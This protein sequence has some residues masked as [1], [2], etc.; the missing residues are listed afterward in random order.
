LK[1]QLLVC[2]SLTDKQDIMPDGSDAPKRSRA[3]EVLRE[4]LQALTSKI[5]GTVSPRK[6]AKS[7][8]NSDVEGAL[9]ALTELKAIK[10]V[11]DN[12]EQTRQKHEEFDKAYADISRK[13]DQIK[14]MQEELRLLKKS[15]NTIEKQ[16]TK[17][18]Q[19]YTDA[20]PKLEATGL[21]LERFILTL[22]SHYFEMVPWAKT[23]VKD[24]T[25]PDE[26]S[27]EDVPNYVYLQQLVLDKVGRIT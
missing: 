20:I 27:W 18:A 7:L 4:P 21:G 9:K 25:K 19:K 26:F 14:K 12:F 13:E 16:K 15:S 2:E 8:S 1:F 23:K 5:D 6:V 24:G 22:E 10:E 17:S 3:S 11:E